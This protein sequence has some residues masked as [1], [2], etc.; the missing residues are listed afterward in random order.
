MAAH[1]VTHIAD[2]GLETPLG[3]LA[4]VAIPQWII[5]GFVMAIVLRGDRAQSRTAALVLGLSV[6]VGFAGVHL[7]PVAPPPTGDL[8]PS[9]VSWLL[10]WTP[11]AAGVVLVALAWPQPHAVPAEA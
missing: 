5:L 9:F 6:V 10:A 4:L 2:D 1:D 7:L 8:E 3:R 11:A